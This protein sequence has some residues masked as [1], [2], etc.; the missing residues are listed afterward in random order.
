MKTCP[1]A[2]DQN[3][4]E[5]TAATDIIAKRRQ[6]LRPCSDLVI[7]YFSHFTRLKGFCPLILQVPLTRK[8]ALRSTVSLDLIL[9]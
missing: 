9:S 1:L 3:R 8:R 4:S 2:S 6:S 7:V 5:L